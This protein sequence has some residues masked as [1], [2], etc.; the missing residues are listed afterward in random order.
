MSCTNELHAQAGVAILFR[1]G[2]AV[3]IKVEGKDRNGRI[4]WTLVEI[5]AKRILI[6][7]IYAPP[8]GDNPNFFQNEV[9]PV[10][11]TVEHDHVVLGGDW[12]LGLDPDLDYYG[13]ARADQVRPKSRQT[14][15]NQTNK[16]DLI[17]IYRELHPTGTEKTWR[18]WNKGS[19]RADKE[20]RLDYFLVDTAMAS[21]VEVTG[22]SSP[23]TSAFDHRPVIM[24][25][26]FN[27]VRRGPGYWKFNNSML[28]ELD[29]CKK[30]RDTIARVLFDYQQREDPTKDPLTMNDILLM[31][32]LQ[33][34]EIPMTLNPH[35]L[36]EFLLFSIKGVARRYGQEKKTDLME[37]KGAAEAKL[38]EKTRR[39]DALLEKYRA[40]QVAQTADALMNIKTEIKLIQKK[41]QDIDTHLNEGAYIRCGTAWKCESE[42]P[43]KIFFQQEK[44]S[45]QQ[46][47]MGILEVEG[48]EPG[49]TRLV[50][51]Q[52]EIEDSIKNFY[53]ELYKKRETSSTDNDLR[54][55]MGDVGYNQ[56]KDS[57]KNN[58]SEYEY[59]KCGL[60]LGK[61]EI[62][63]A[64]NHGKHGVAPGIS[65]FSREFYKHFSTNLIEFIMKYVQ[66]TEEQG[67]L[68]DSQRIGVI[69]LLPKGQKDKKNLKNWRPI[70]LLSTLYKI[71]SGA[72]GNR[73]KKFLPNLIGQSQKG[74]VDGR[75]MSEVTRMLYDTIVD[76]Y[77][78]KNKKGII[79]SIDFEKA[80]DS[81]SFAFIERVVETAG[82]PKAMKDWVKILLKDFKSHINHAG[83]LLKLID[84]GRGARQGDP[85]ASI[86]F[87]LAIE[88][89]LITIRNNESIEPYTFLIQFNQTLEHKV[90][91]Y[92]DDVNLTMPRKESTIREVLS[93]LKQFEKLSG[94]KVNQDKTQVLR[95]GKDAESD[96]VLCP[97]LG[98]R[99]V[100]K[101]KV[102]GINLMASPGKMESNFDDK[103]EEIDKLLNSWTFRNMTV[104]GRIMVVK[105][106]ALSKITH[107]IQVIPNPNP[108][109]VIKL[110]KLINNFIWKGKNQKKVVVNKD[111]AEQP[112]NKGGLAIP[113]LNQF[114][115]SLKLA[116]L[117][118][119]ITADDDSTWK[120]LSMARLGTALNIPG[121][122]STRLLA[123]G[124]H[125]IGKAADTLSNPFWK[126]LFKLMPT[127]EKSFYTP[128]SKI[129]GER[130]IWG[131]NDYLLRGK[132]LSRKTCSPRL[133]RNLNNI[134]DFMSKTTNE[135]LTEA[136]ATRLLGRENVPLW[137]KITATITTQLTNQGKSWH[138]IDQ[139]APGP[140]HEGWSRMVLE[141]P[142]AKNF[143]NLFSTAKASG[144]RNTNERYWINQGLTTYNNTR[145]DNLWKNFSK[146]R[147]NLRVKYEEYRVLWG[148]QELNKYK[149]KYAPLPGGNSVACSY[150]HEVIETEKHLYVDCEVTGEFWQ[151]AK[152]WFSQLFKVTPTLA[153]KGPRLFGL[154]KEQPDDLLNIFY[155]CARFCIYNNRSKTSLPSLEFFAN[156]VRDELKVKYRGKKFTKH[157]ASPDEAAAIQW[158]KVEMGWSQSLPEKMYPETNKS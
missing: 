39:H 41:L 71:I 9:F 31:T 86:L 83:N 149:D 158:M 45:G 95:I 118:R 54:Q 103:I 6:I 73:F 137:N 130:S 44:W 135:L 58:I 123:E 15:I 147:C 68:S 80:F 3:D 53:A 85:I 156:L 47:F 115:N 33:Q 139:S 1:S 17:D 102:L 34:A 66:F 84:L 112:A 22:V 113:N 30:V 40:G 72:V 98:L 89:L 153:L 154:E 132:P 125:T 29:F 13:Y 92:A 35:Q 90:A 127:I 27:K 108:A 114:W 120:R 79:M 131:N 74:F 65:G 16:Y 64:I 152:S 144:D 5:Y 62:L 2:L 81:V 141:C 42:S 145:W 148:R 133:V 96:P 142:R 43:S 107:L 24:K 157:A 106:L 25:V 100:T 56:F 46:R 18:Q 105:T 36:L 104:Y 4:V 99:W 88:I 97:D 78:T 7:G 59:E 110:Q 19:Q 138:S 49:T 116:W 11:D 111:I 119:L 8:S 124:P 126:S 82:F 75:Q 76:A 129:F 122:T 14:L 134:Q 28:D 136:E 128:T 21:Y 48:D 93:T 91:A 26:D 51:N 63:A 155:R 143:Y 23:Y 50:T 146:L 69:T 87:V 12:N 94:L 109:N 77:S 70:T 55:F 20:A 117:T 67:L 60:P 61:D 52:P 37:S 121:L 150:C 151:S 32:P 10:L 38:M 101:L 57:A 140:S